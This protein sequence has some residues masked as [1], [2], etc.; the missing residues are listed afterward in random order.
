LQ[1][2]QKGIVEGWDD[3]RMPTISGLRRR[4]YSPES[5]KNFATRIGVAKRDGIID[6]ALLEFSVREHLNKT[7]PRRMAVP[8]PVKLII[9]NY[10]KEEEWLDAVNNPEDETAGKRKIP[11][12]GEVYIDRGDFMIDPPKKFFRLGPDREVRLKYAYIIKCEGYKLDENGE[13]EEIYCTYDPE[14]KSGSGNNRKVKGTLGWVSAKHCIEAEI[15]LY[16]RLFNV[17]SPGGDDFIDH[18]NPDSLT[19]IK[20][21]VLEPSLADARPLDAVQFER[22]GYFTPDKNSVSDKL[23]FNRTVTLR[24]TWE[25]K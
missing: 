16:D 11:F 9:K 25:G 20:G 14:T 5:I 12:S 7:A 8:D 24:D 17:E 10:D 18:I 2:V 4:G 6:V 19:I 23:V 21:A 22:Q 13:V 15:R 1:L 3:P